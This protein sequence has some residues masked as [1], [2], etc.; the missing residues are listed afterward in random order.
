MLHLIPLIYHHSHTAVFIPDQC[1]NV[2][3]DVQNV[4]NSRGSNE[5]GGTGEALSLFS[6]LKT[7]CQHFILPV[8]S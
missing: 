2:I 7:K 8:I 5:R 3:M 4:S 1:R 6:V